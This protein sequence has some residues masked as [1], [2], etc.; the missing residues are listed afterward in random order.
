MDPGSLE[1]GVVNAKAVYLGQLG[2]EVTG[3]VLMRK[4]PEKSN[5]Q[6]PEE[7]ERTLKKRLGR[8]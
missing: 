3:W 4:S 8:C 5:W 1:S 6:R 7:E 2:K